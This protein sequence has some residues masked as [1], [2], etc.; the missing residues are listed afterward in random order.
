MLYL[1]SMLSVLAAIG[2]AV[3]VIFNALCDHA[4]A[5]VAAL[6]GRSVGAE[7]IRE[8]APCVRV[9]VRTPARRPVLRLHLRAAA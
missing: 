5:I 8:S 3:A 1:V 2:S 6:A 7:A 9:S 4:D